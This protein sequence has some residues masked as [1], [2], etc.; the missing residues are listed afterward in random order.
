M[1]PH[2]IRTAARGAWIALTLALI[3]ALASAGT[4]E[5]STF[6]AETQEEDDESVIDHLLTRPP[7][8]WRDAWERAPLVFQSSQGCLTS[9]QWLM[10]TRLK[11]E[12][13]LGRTARFA[14]DYTQTED[15]ISTYQFL[16]LWFHFPS[17]LGTIGAMFR[18]FH[19]KSRQDF[20]LAWEVG[21]DS[22]AFQ[23][24]ATYGFEDLFNNL[25]AWRQVRVGNSPE[26]Y[27]R[28]PWEPALAIACRHER[29]RA[30]L[31]G[32]YLSPSIKRL[33]GVATLDPPH[34]E[35][36]WGTLADALVEARALGWRWEA[37]G[38]VHQARSTDQPIDL[39]AGDHHDFRR[40]WTAEAAVGRA[41]TPRLNAE[42][43]YA[44][45]GR[46]ENYGPP[47]ATG[48]YD[49]IDRVLQFELRSTV[50]P[51]LAARIG[52]LHDQI[53]VDRTGVTL[54]GGE[55]TRKESRAYL[56]LDA[57]FG[58]VRVMGVEGIELDVEPYDVWFHHDKAFLALQST[59]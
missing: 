47:L 26:P 59:F 36:L 11:L 23:V 19:D 15:D 7:P 55:G 44:Y 43:R 27:L 48:T 51:S 29:W 10:D 38:H 5:F 1:A 12:T 34:D 45:G 57:R 17:R 22:S 16:D 33:P 30:E 25:W 20:A 56:G 28:H 42:A 37:R 58:R 40:S 6:H 18:P 52:Y 13:P 24:R 8:E 3:A 39:S 2:L 50:A 46:T 9:G 53:T 49:D 14:L 35:T 4:E 54:A 31:V 41:L 21:S 32:K